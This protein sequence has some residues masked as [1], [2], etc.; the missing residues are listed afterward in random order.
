M[1]HNSQIVSIL[2]WKVC[3]TD[4]SGS[5]IFTLTNKDRLLWPS[6][7]DKFYIYMY[8]FS[9]SQLKFTLT[10]VFAKLRTQIPSPFICQNL[11]YVLSLSLFVPKH[12]DVTWFLPC[13][14]PRFT[15]G[16]GFFVCTQ[17]AQHCNFCLTNH[18]I[19]HARLRYAR[20]SSGKSPDPVTKI[21]CGFDQSQYL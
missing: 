20:Y 11:A 18:K 10:V 12:W 5:T 16:V 6:Q 15:R 21:P 7:I 13:V 17:L 4:Q 14:Q 2:R 3:R 19:T 9:C 8:K 1:D